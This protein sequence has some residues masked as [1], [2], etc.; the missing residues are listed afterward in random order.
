MLSFDITDRFVASKFYFKE[1]IDKKLTLEEL[2]KYPFVLLSPITHGRKNFDMFIRSH[3][4]NFKPTYEFNSYSLCRDLIK[5][6][7]GIGIGNPIHYPLDK[8][9]I[10]DTDFELPKRT[11]NIGYIKNSKNQLIK[12]FIDLL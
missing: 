6:G 12:D 11:F 1:L 9:I 2:L 4:K 10:I 7:F 8:F 5:N 3:N